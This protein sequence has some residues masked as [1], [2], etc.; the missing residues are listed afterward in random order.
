[1]T[2]WIEIKLKKA[3]LLH[4]LTNRLRQLQNQHKNIVFRQVTPSSL[5]FKQTGKLQLKIYISLK[6]PSI[7]YIPGFIQ[8]SFQICQHILQS[9]QNFSLQ[10]TAPTVSA[11]IFLSFLINDIY[12]FCVSFY[13]ILN[14][15]LLLLSIWF[16]PRTW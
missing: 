10:S 2:L 8:K 12:Y 3:P 11:K 16:C 14:C 13:W 4:D 1:M 7:G 9:V 5:P 6:T 15:M